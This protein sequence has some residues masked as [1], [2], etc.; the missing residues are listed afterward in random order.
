MVKNSCHGHRRVAII[1]TVY[2]FNSVAETGEKAGDVATAG[3]QEEH[4]K[5]SGLKGGH[6]QLSTRRLQFFTLLD[7][8][9]SS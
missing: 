9:V 7:L 1:C 5:M 8:C 3:R 4:E 2:H 6:L